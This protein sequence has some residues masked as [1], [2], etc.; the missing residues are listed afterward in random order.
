MQDYL[1]WKALM[2]LPLAGRLTLTCTV[3]NCQFLQM[4]DY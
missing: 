2:N 1:V 3:T 4:N